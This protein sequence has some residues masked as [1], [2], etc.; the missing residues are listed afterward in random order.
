MFCEILKGENTHLLS[1]DHVP[2]LFPK[3]DLIISNLQRK[4]PRISR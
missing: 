4:K 1:T 3:V 2:G